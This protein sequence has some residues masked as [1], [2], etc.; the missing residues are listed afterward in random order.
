M[1]ANPQ[2]RP[3]ADPQPRP[4]KER[5]DLSA[6][7][8]DR[9]AE[10]PIGVQLAWS[11]R[12]RIG[13]GEYAPGQRLP[14][15]RDLADAIGVNLNTVRTVYQRL[16]HEGL[17]ESQQGSGT[18]VAPSS[19]AGSSVLAIAA[20]AARAAREGGV[21]PRAV[22]AALY[23]TPAPPP[24]SAEEAADLSEIGQRRLLRRQIA[25]FE[26]ALAE[27]EA[28]NPGVAPAAEPGRADA[29]PSLLGTLEL[30]AVRTAL[31]RRLAIVQAAID[32]HEQIVRGR[33][34]PSASAPAERHREATS[35]D[36][37]APAPAPKRARRARA[38]TQI[39]PANT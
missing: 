9:D 39:L 3:A 6:L 15:L 36:R 10:V 5:D 38:G 8:V 12:T 1:T 29:G 14:G 25:A 2:P 24:Q 31:V 16:E 33:K 22:A 28:A 4:A 11:L 20:T 35:G 21:D 13:D 23:V 37:A 32:E 18:F 34:P 27:I 30:E 7:S 26:S 17:I 19:P